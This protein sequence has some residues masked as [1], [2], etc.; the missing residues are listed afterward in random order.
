MR[1]RNVKVNSYV[2]LRNFKEYGQKMKKTYPNLN[3]L[4][5]FLW[6]LFTSNMN[7]SNSNRKECEIPR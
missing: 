2:M 6:I 7:D 5:P 1:N 4:Q 3:L